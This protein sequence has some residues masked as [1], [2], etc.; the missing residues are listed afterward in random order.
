MLEV[1]NGDM[2]TT[3]YITHFSLLALMEVLYCLLLTNSS[4]SDD[5]VSGYIILIS[6]IITIDKLHLIIS[7]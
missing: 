1:G 2:S 3:E 5:R 4:N 6:K 7:I